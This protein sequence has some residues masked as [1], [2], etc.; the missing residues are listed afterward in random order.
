MMLA[1]ALWSLGKR[2]FQLDVP[3]QTMNSMSFIAKRRT[4][5]KS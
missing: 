5:L 2:E 3:G 1:N 4:R